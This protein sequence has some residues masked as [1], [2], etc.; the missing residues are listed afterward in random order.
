LELQLR[1]D[2]GDTVCLG[3]ATNTLV[4]V[5]GGAM[6]MV[7]DADLVGSATLVAVIVMVWLLVTEAGAV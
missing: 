3:Q 2:P 7:V 6:V 1:E 5:T 4:M